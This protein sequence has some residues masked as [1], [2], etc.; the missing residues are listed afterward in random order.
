MLARQSNVLQ[1]NSPERLAARLTIRPVT[2]PSTRP[3]TRPVTRL[4]V[5]LSVLLAV[6]LV[7]WLRR[8]AAALAA[9][10]LAAAA[11][12]AAAL[13]AAALAAAALTAAALAAAVA[14]PLAAGAAAVHG[15][16]NVLP[17]CLQTTCGQLLR[18]VLWWQ[19]TRLASR[20]RVLDLSRVHI[21]QRTL[22]YALAVT[23]AQDRG[24]DARC[25]VSTRSSRQK[26]T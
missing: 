26:T 23:A 18:M 24:R 7:A 25:A 21:E 12:A 6:L 17:L 15:P 13:A 19:R 5:M 22:S 3:V 9:A 8:C 16:R 10:A 14:A 4:S 1:R 2:K 20:D 11:L